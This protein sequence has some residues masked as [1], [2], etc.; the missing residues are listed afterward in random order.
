[1]IDIENYLNDGANE[2]AVAVLAFLRG[3]KDSILE[4]S[5][6][7]KWG[8]RAYF[9][10][11][12][13]ENCREQGYVFSIFWKGKQKNYAVYEHRNSDELIVLISNV[14]TINTPSVKDMWAD[15]GENPSKYD[16]DKEFE[17][18][19]ILGCVEWIKNDMKATIDEWAKI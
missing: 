8:Y 6:D 2:Q 19:D 17:Y 13:Y 12:R 3:A 16:Y 7:E 15:K 4:P 5:R 14:C 1:M 10:V 9:E 18:G 11:G